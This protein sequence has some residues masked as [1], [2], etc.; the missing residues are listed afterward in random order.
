MRGAGKVLT[1]RTFDLVRKALADPA[2]SVVDAALQLLRKTRL[3]RRRC[4]R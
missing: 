3:R 1:P 4:R 2:P